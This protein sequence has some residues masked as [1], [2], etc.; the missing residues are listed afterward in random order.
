MPCYHPLKAFVTGYD[1]NG[2]KKLRF[3]RKGEDFDSYTKEH[4]KDKCLL[5]PCGQCLGCRLEYSRQWAMRCALEASQYEHNYFLT[6]TYDGKFLP[7]NAVAKINRSTGEVTTELKSTLVKRHVQLFMKRLRKYI[8]AKY[9][10]TGVRFYACGEYGSKNGRAHYHLILFNCPLEL[11]F[12]NAKDGFTYYTSPDISKTWV[13]GKDDPV[14]G[15]EFGFH[16]VSEFTF[17]T[18]AYVAR[19][20]LKKHKGLDSGYYEENGIAPEFTTCSRRPGIGRAFFD[21]NVD[22]IYDFD[23]ITI[24][25]LNGSLTCKPP[26]YYDK[27]LAE[28]YPEIMEQVKGIRS[29]WL[30]IE[31]GKAMMHTDLDEDEYRVVCEQNKSLSIQSLVRNL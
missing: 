19:Y 13:T 24:P 2:V 21:A 11:E 30:E 28:K 26:K 4:Y 31:N 17:D 8:K 12:F 23:S 7:L 6:L 29:D 27:I 15:L 18:A 22:K 14:E 1:E 16:L 5:L 10:H 3:L 25:Q 9:G 20:M